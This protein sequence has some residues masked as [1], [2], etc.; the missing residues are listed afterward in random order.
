M[1]NLSKYCS[2]KISKCISVRPKKRMKRGEA[3]EERGSPGYL[4]DIHRR[5]LQNSAPEVLETVI[6]LRILGIGCNAEARDQ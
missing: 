4:E 6:K 1:I 2:F 3:E 5:N